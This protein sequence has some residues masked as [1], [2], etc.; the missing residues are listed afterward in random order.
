MRSVASFRKWRDETPDDFDYS[1]K[2]DRAV[3]KSRKLAEGGASI[4]W[5]FRSGVLELGEIL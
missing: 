3:V 4:E 1:V 5:F 2:G